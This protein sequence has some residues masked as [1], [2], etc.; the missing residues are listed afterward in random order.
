MHSGLAG[1]ALLGWLAWPLA[2]RADVEWCYDDPPVLVRLPSGAPVNVNVQVGVPA[3]YRADLQATQAWAEYAGSTD[4]P[5]IVV[6]VFVPADP[7][8]AFPVQVTA[9]AGK[10]QTAVA[11]SGRAGHIITLTLS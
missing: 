3:A 9:T 7:G 2:A 5:G 11:G 10:V 8:D 1:L 4:N 6:Y